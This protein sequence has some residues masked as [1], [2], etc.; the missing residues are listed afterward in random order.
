[1]QVPERTVK[2]QVSNE[3]AASKDA[4]AKKEQEVEQAHMSTHTHAY[5]CCTH[6]SIH[7]ESRRL[8]SYIVIATTRLVRFGL[9]RMRL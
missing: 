6:T 8:W 9:S 5:R 3:L 4:M 1:M 7:I 2:P